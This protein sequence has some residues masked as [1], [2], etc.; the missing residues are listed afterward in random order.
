MKALCGDTDTKVNR[1]LCSALADYANSLLPLY[2]VH[3]RSH[4]W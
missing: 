1:E 3:R 4:E 2:S